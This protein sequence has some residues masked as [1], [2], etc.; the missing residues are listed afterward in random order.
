MKGISIATFI[1]KNECENKEFYELVEYIRKYIEVEVL[2]FSN[3]KIEEG[4]LRNFINPEMT[5]YKRIQKLLKESRF[6]DILCIDNDVK[7]NKVNI[8]NFI[9]NCLN[10]DYSIAWGKVKA[11]N[12]KGVIPKLIEIDKNLSHNYIRPALWKLNIGISLPGQIFM[13]NKNYLENK[14][15]SID[16]VYDDLMIGAVVR[17]NEYPIYFVK[18]ILGYEKPKRNIKELLKQRIR[19]AKG[20]AETIMYNKKNKIL[21]YILLHGFA[22]N[23]LWIPVCIILY[24]I[25]KNNMF[26]GAFLTML[27]CYYLTEKKVKNIVWAMMYMAVFPYVYLVWG[28]SLMYNLIKLCFNSKRKL[29]KKTTIVTA[30]NII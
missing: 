15:P 26:L 3:N 18:D 24:S 19:W 14:L 29:N 9:N 30:K 13:M 1:S 20:L 8:L 4:S 21:K 12:I 11:D 27:I 7:P 10:M 22:F 16:T 23:L 2:I 17:E 5:K 6:N 28:I 25:T